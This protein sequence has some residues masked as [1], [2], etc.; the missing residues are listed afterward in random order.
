MLTITKDGIKQLEKELNELLD[1]KLPKIIERITKAREHGDL[2]ENAEYQQAVNEKDIIMARIE[3][4]KHVLETAKVVKDKKSTKGIQIGSKVKIK[5]IATGQV[6]EYT[7]VGE[8]ESSPAE[9]KI[10]SASPVGRALIGK[11]VG[12]KVCVKAPV[13]EINYIIESIS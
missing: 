7:I 4:I 9:G 12:D 8:F 13:G 1:E 3:E 5:N 2:S 10:S 11:S 6:F